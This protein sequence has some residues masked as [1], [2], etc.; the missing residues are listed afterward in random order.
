MI[1]ADSADTLYY[2]L[3]SKLTDEGAHVEALPRGMALTGETIGEHLVLRNPRLSVIGLKQ[4]QL[5]YQFMVAEAVW[6]MLGRNDTA[7]LSH[8]CSEITKFSDDGLIFFGAY[9]PHI[10]RQLNYLINTLVKDKHSRQAV[11]TIWQQNPEPSKDIPCTVSMQALVRDDKL[12]LLVTMRSS[13]AWLGI[14][15]DVFNFSLILNALAG[16][17]GYGLGE[18]HLFLGSSHLYERNGAAARAVLEAYEQLDDMGVLFPQVVLPALPGW[19]PPAFKVWEQSARLEGRVLV[20]IDCEPWYSLLE[21][22]AS[23]RLL[24]P[25]YKGYFK[26]VLPCA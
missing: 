10:Q 1:I 14:P 18:L 4:R 15:Y 16:G 7:M 3:L 19:L 9:G 17:L 22:L 26:E 25:S 13:D 12:S 21:V 5:N 20:P 8:Y 2:L 11:L 24:Q 6:I 23:R